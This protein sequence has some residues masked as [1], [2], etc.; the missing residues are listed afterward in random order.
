MIENL[1]DEFI[2]FITSRAVIL[3]A[4]IV[5]SSCIMI[6]RLFDLQ[7]IR[8]ESYLDDYKVMITKNNPIPATRGNIYD[9]NDNLLAY[10][11]IANSVTIE[12]VYKSGKGKN[13]AINETLNNVIDII[14]KNNDHVDHDFSIVLDDSNNYIFTVSDTNLE[15]FLADVYG[16]AKIK[17]LKYEEKIKTPD[18]VVDDLCKNFGIT[19][20]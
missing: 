19:F 10:N 4:V 17:D 3:C 14:E 2:K 8:G 7:I 12:D 5:C 6:Y 20:P 11:D 1:K 13:A 15:R 9:R 18:E 16:H